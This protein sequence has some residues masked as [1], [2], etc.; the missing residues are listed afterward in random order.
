MC[1]HPRQPII[2][3]VRSEC[4]SP[5]IEQLFHPANQVL[6]PILCLQCVTG[7]VAE[8]DLVSGCKLSSAESGGSPVCLQYTADGS[9]L[10]AVLK[11]VQ[12]LSWAASNP[13]CGNRDD[14]ASLAGQR[15]VAVNHSC[16]LM[17]RLAHL[18]EG[19]PNILLL[20]VQLISC[21]FKR[22]ALLLSLLPYCMRPLQSPPVMGVNWMLQERAVLSWS[23]QLWKRRVLLEPGKSSEK[24]MF[25]AHL[26]ISGASAHLAPLHRTSFEQGPWPC[27]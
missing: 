16:V 12:E 7:T 4:G 15:T 2:A 13:P 19:P 20:V 26:A 9:Q 27:Q 18:Q 8:F 5:I 6:T 1:L 10:I 11:V 24:P 23:Q 3:V 14:H 21:T 17:L 25:N 22:V